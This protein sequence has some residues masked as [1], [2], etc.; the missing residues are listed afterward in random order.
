MTV[1]IAHGR[2]LRAEPAPVSGLLLHLAHGRVLVAFAGLGLA[3]RQT[4]VVVARAVHD[5]YLDPTIGGR[6]GHDAAG[7]AHDIVARHIH[8]RSRRSR[9][10][11]HASASDARART[12]RVRSI[13]ASMPSAYAS[14]GLLSGAV[15]VSQLSATT[16]S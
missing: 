11:S 15:L 6:P 2:E 3:F 13:S 16:E 4:P 1:S 9:A 14:D 12:L 7:G 10:A 5:Q 8:A